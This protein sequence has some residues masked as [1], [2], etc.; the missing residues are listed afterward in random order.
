MHR[1]RSS[2]H[3]I[4]DKPENINVDGVDKIEPSSVK[5]DKGKARSIL[6]TITES[7]C[8]V[9]ES[10]EG[11]DKIVKFFQYAAMFASWQFVRCATNMTMAA[12]AQ[13][14]ANVKFK[15][16]VSGLLEKAQLFTEISRK[17]TR[18]TSRLLLSLK[19]TIDCF[20]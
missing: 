13:L 7:F 5:K 15:G 2:I 16:R 11:R 8:L 14:K 3:Q 6:S 20:L 18:S 12:S 10:C 17:F 4:D 9:T 1:R 19:L